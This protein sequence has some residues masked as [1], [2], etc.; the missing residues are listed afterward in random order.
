M[1]HGEIFSVGA[2]ADLAGPRVYERGVGY[3]ADG[4]VE[5]DAPGDRRMEATV[6][7]SI[8]YTVELWIDREEPGWSC[9]CP[10]AEDGSFCK[11]CVAVALQLADGPV[12]MVAPMPDPADM[13]LGADAVSYTHLRAHETVLDLV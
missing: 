5:L 11:H 9:S 10:A 3:Y 7:G 12:S 1:N 6:R 2:I 8:P 4:R 13:G